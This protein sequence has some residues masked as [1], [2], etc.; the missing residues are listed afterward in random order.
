[1]KFKSAKQKWT[2]VVIPDHQRS[3]FQLN[4]SQLILYLIPLLVVSLLGLTFM[5][6]V[7]NQ[8]TGQQ[9][10]ELKR[11]M[12]TLKQA[13]RQTMAAKEMQIEKLQTH[14]LMMSEQADEVQDKMSELIKLEHELIVMTQ[15]DPELFRFN[16]H[17]KERPVQIAAFSAAEHF[18]GVPEHEIS[19][20]ELMHLA[21]QTRERLSILNEQMNA[22]TGDLS[23]AVDLAARYQ[24]TMQRTP[25]I[26]PTESKQVTSRFGY[27]K[28]PFTYRTSLHSGIDIA[29]THGDSVY[30]AADGTVLKSGYD[31]SKGHYIEINHGQGLRTVYMHLSKRSVKAGERVSKGD[32][33]G[34]LGSTGRSTGPHLHYEVFKNGAVVNPVT[35]MK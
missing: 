11:Q 16:Q 19:D 18:S 15:S 25:S 3:S 8:Q 23:L 35:Y 29:G 21:N 32:I 6:H 26:W 28:D 1:M 7:W 14:V 27:R 12:A 34:Q 5:L 17:P 33:I 22:L 10:I 13:M 30:A 31:R 2:I 9:N 20:D 4:F 24:E